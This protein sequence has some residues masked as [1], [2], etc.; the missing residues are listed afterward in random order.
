MHPNALRCAVL[1]HIHPAPRA[2][3]R[4]EPGNTTRLPAMLCCMERFPLVV[5]LCVTVGCA[6]PG[7]PEPVSP[8][9]PDAEPADDPRTMLLCTSVLGT[10][11]SVA[12]FLARHGIEARDHI[13]D[14]GR[15][16]VYVQGRRAAFRARDLLRT[17]A[18]PQTITWPGDYIVGAATGETILAHVEFARTPSP[19][20]IS[21]LERAGVGTRVYFGKTRDMIIVHSTD[22]ARAR[23]LLRRAAFPGVTLRD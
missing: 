7:A 23:D 18:A 17:P 14:M 2:P 3:H 10:S 12:K 4:V 9:A 19:S 11:G 6:A 16:D 8:P 21:G 1:R 5:A 13:G 20:V 15:S 22:Q